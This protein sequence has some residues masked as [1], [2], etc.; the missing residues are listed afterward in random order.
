MATKT[1][2]VT[3]PKTPGAEP[4][5]IATCATIAEARKVA[6]G[7]SGRRDLTYQDVVIRRGA[8]IVERCGPAR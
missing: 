7:F 6:A 2:T 1:L 4:T 8:R 3:A 5:V